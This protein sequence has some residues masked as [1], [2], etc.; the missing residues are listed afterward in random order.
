MVTKTPR[1][2]LISDVHY[3]LPTLEIADRAT[4]MAVDKANELRVPLI[5]SGDLHDTK[6]SLRAECVHDIRKTLSQTNEWLYVICGNHDMVHEK[7]DKHALDFLEPI[8][9]LLV[10]LPAFSYRLGLY[11]IPYYHDKEELKEYL[12]TIPRGSTVVMHQGL[13]G[14]KSGEYILDH[15]A[16]T[17]DDVAGLNVVS[18]HYHTRQTIELPSGGM[19]TFLGNPYTKTFAEA[20]DPE[21][22]FHIMYSD[23]SLEFVPT[24]L[25]RHVVAVCEF[26]G[27]ALV[28]NQTSEIQPDSILLVKVRGT[29]EELAGVTK[30][31]LRQNLNIP[32]PDFRLELILTDIGVKEPISTNLS[33]A[34]LLDQA[35]DSASGLAPETKR[36]LQELWRTLR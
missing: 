11:M 27:A 21:K 10:D 30:D 16:I 22:G 8:P 4:K 2:V 36:R 31:G 24:N 1:A 29:R 13:Q 28:I 26:R 15:S 35:I 32:T 3:S 9:D 25:R 7:S 14:T 23:S 5:I 17:P 6:A 19:W 20:S 33:H 34:E 12:K 18:G